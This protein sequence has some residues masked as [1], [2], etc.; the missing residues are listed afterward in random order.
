[1]DSRVQFKHP[2]SA[3]DTPSLCLW[4]KRK[5]L[6]IPFP[7]DNPLG[8]ALVYKVL[9]VNLYLLFFLLNIL[10]SLPSS[11]NHMVQFLAPS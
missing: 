3:W 2:S 4:D 1:M 7:S 6:L 11:P 5:S 9:H 10:C 8:S